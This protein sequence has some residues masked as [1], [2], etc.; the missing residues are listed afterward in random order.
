MAQVASGAPAG[1]G[2]KCIA[3]LLMLTG[4]LLG[5][6]AALA[7]ASTGAATET[8]TSG[9]TLPDRDTVIRELQLE[10]HVEG[11]YFRR[12]YQADDQPRV[13]TPAGE[14][15]SLTSIHYLLTADS[16]TGH[17]HLNR[18][19]IVHYWHLGAP[20]EYFMIHPDGRLETAVLGPDLA[21]G[22]RLQLTVK[23]GV[24]KASH[25]SAGDYGLISEA[26]SP[27]FEY[28]DMTLGERDVLLARFPQHR[29]L[30]QAY[31]RK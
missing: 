5:G 15:Y 20:V 2:V 17:W 6:N 19:D 28:A 12:T 8:T 10:S 1:R 13:A 22:Q 3:G 4:T 27:G 30:I 21:A 11:G 26:V 9:F 23:G 18:S 7:G 16:P 14:R 25:L 31:T 24:W 29:A